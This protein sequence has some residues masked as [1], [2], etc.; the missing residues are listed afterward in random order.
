MNEN[1]FGLTVQKFTTAKV[2]NAHFQFL[3]LPRRGT[4]PGTTSVG[5]T[6]MP[7]AVHHNLRPPH[8]LLCRG[9][10]AVLFHAAS[11]CRQGTSTPSH[12]RLVVGHVEPHY[13]HMY[14]CTHIY[15]TN[16][17][18]YT[19]IAHRAGHSYGRCTHIHNLLRSIRPN[20]DIHIA[21]SK[22]I[23]RFCDRTSG[24]DTPRGKPPFDLSA[25]DESLP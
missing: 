17:K 4:A 10:Q 21:K 12:K 22:L 3:G 23:L 7:L 5:C 24:R 16:T 8:T 1:P 20:I 25:V 11:K 14:I 18:H 19:Y 15:T 6:R 13:T 9:K 2:Y